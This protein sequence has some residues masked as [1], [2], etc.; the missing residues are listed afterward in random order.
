MIDLRMRYCAGGGGTPPDQNSQ[1]ARA[2]A[3]GNSSQPPTAFTP[4]LLASAAAL[5]A[6]TN[7]TNRFTSASAQTTAAAIA[8]A[9]SGVPLMP[10]PTFP[11]GSY[12]GGFA[13]GLFAGLPPGAFNNSGALDGAGGPTNGLTY[14][15]TD[16]NGNRFTSSRTDTV[17]LTLA[18]GVPQTLNVQNN[19]TDTCAMGCGSSVSTLVASIRNATLAQLSGDQFI[20]TGRLKGGMGTFSATDSQSGFSTGTLTRTL[21]SNISTYFAFGVPATMLPS[22]GTFN[23]NLLS[24]T[25]PTFADGHGGLGTFTGALSIKFGVPSSS[26]FNP[27]SGVSVS[28]PVSGVLVG[29]NFSVS[30]LDGATYNL[31]TIGGPGNPMAQL[32]FIQAVFNSANQPL[33]QPVPGTVFAIIIQRQGSF[34]GL[35]NVT[36]IGPGT[37]CT[38]SCLASLSGFLAGPRGS[39]VGILYSFGG[40]IPN[41]PVNLARVIVGSAVF[42]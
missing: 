38:A 17:N 22:Q 41:G 31:S 20:Q 14:T 3:T 11:N 19:R 33:Q 21:P 10:P 34:G 32:P 15:S 13:G 28:G 30:G 40:G 8:A 18:N 5:G 23:Y 42:R 26:F 37:A 2:V 4:T 36:V 12:A 6:V 35:P 27:T 1:S 39:R 29:L 7:A 16:P 25:A 9:Q 24:A